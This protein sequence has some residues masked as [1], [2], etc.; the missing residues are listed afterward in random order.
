M[1]A[2]PNNNVGDPRIQPGLF[3]GR[4]EGMGETNQP[5]TPADGQARSSQGNRPRVVRQDVRAIQDLLWNE[6]LL[7]VHQAERFHNDEA[8]HEHLRHHLPQN[9]LETRT[10][11]AQTLVRWFF[12]DGVRGLAASVWIHY[13]SQA[14]LEEVLRFLYLGAE[15]MGA[16]AV[17]EALFPIA[18]NARIPP[19]YLT[20]FLRQRFGDTTPDKTVKRVK[21]N[22]RKLSFLV[23]EKGEA[24]DTLRAMGPSA[25]GFL[26][27]LHYLFA[28][29]EPRAVE[30]RALAENPFWK[31]LGFKSEDQLRS[32]LKVSL[33]RGLIAKYVVADRIESISLRFTFHEF[34]TKQMAL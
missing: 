21:S 27:V 7:A 29:E 15:P 34:V 14:L 13:R 26:V 1:K 11:Y 24:T 5:E 4:D 16:A 33:G 22:L 19:S 23:R 32:I 9:S 2:K 6:A 31:Y 30:F 28:R 20:N 18:E 25:T 3:D 10:R 12:P 8:F 17:S